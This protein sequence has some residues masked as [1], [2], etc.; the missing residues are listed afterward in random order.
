MIWFILL[1]YYDKKKIK[2]GACLYILILTKL[3]CH[4]QHGTYISTF[5]IL[6]YTSESVGL[7]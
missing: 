6:L 2:K 1:D 3:L 5:K 4:L 7:L